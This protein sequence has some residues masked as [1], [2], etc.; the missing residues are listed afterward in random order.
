MVLTAGQVVTGQ[1]FGN[2]QSEI[3]GPKWNDLNGN[4]VRDPGEPGLAGW[5]IYLDTNGNGQLDP[6]EPSTVT[7]PDGSYAFTGLAPNTYTVAEVKQSG[8]AQTFPATQRLFEVRASGTTATI[9]EVNPSTGAVINSF[10]A[11]RR[12]SSMARRAWPLGP[13]ACSTSMGP[14]ATHTRC[15]S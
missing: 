14:S 15:M 13:T 9:L 5:T 1:D 8:T 11:P 7:G 10:A 3:R 12:F 6:G 2:R 4:G